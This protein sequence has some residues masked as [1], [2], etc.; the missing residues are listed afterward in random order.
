LT[1]NFIDIISS[2]EDWVLDLFLG[3]SDIYDITNM[4]VEFVEAQF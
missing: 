2:E 1:N 3:L 4:K